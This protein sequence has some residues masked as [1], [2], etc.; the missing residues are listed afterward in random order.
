DNLTKLWLTKRA[1]RELDRRN[2][3][4]APSTSQSLHQHARRPVT[5]K[6]IVEQ[7][8]TCHVAHCTNYLSR[9]TPRILKNIRLFA[10]HRGP[11]LSDLRNVC[12]A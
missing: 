4:A 2:S 7:N 9:C 6:S 5:R 1:L 12:M 3:Q 8:T 10:R 11:D